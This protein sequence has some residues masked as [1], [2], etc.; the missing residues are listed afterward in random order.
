LKN[1]ITHAW[2]SIADPNLRAIV[3][4]KER[5]KAQTFAVLLKEDDWRMSL[6]IL[7]HVHPLDARLTYRHAVLF[8]G[9]LPVM[10][11]NTEVVPSSPR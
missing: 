8:L 5:R 10:V 3:A 7:V 9:Q 11:V 6:Q 4:A 2:D 1:R